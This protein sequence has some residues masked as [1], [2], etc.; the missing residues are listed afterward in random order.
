MVSQS[1]CLQVLRLTT[2]SAQSSTLKYMVRHQTGFEIVSKNCKD[3][4]LRDGHPHE[5][6]GSNGVNR[7]DED[8]LCHAWTD[9]GARDV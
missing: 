1:H 3:G 9:D 4:G 8:R 5:I 6:G 7:S 2:D